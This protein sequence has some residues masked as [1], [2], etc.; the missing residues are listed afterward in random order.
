MESENFKCDFCQLFISLDLR[1]L[2]N[3]IYVA[4]SQDLNFKCHCVVGGCSLVFTKYNSL[5]KHTI[6]HHKQVYDNCS[7]Y[8][9]Q[10]R[11]E[12]AAQDESNH[13]LND[14]GNISSSMSDIGCL[15]HDSNNSDHEEDLLHQHSSSDEEEFQSGIDSDIGV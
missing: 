11:T 2:L 13:S 6:R 9:R 3:H 5:Y 7:V 14:E 4:H 1:T 15:D 10:N 8:R 12:S